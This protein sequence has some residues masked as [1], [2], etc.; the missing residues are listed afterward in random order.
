MSEAVECHGC[1]LEERVDGVIADVGQLRVGGGFDGGL[2]QPMVSSNGGSSL[3]PW[4]FNTI[5]F[6]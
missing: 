1:L 5:K 6:K 3:V 2:E 4:K